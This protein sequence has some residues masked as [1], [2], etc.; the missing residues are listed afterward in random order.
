MYEM[1]ERGT[2]CLTDGCNW[3]KKPMKVPFFFFSFLFFLFPFL[4]HFLP[5]SSLQKIFINFPFH[6]AAR[7]A[8]RGFHDYMRN[9]HHKIYDL[10]SGAYCLLK[11]LENAQVCHFISNY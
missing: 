11:A 1:S 9:N 2:L 3:G 4:F 7:V 5:S 6:Q 8:N 10:K